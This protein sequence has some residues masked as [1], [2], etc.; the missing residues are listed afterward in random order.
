MRTVQ[1]QTVGRF[2]LANASG[3]DP[4][5]AFGRL[6]MLVVALLALGVLL[7]ARTEP[8]VPS[9]AA[10]TVVEPAGVEPTGNGPTG[11]FPDTFERIRGEVEPLPPTF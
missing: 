11:Y 6:K 7:M 9:A 8:L 2:S 10:G 3:F 5:A 4:S 1:V